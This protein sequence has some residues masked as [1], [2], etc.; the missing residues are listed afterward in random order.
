MKIEF[1]FGDI[2]VSYEGKPEDFNPT[3]DPSWTPQNPYMEYYEKMFEKL[4]SD[5]MHYYKGVNK[6]FEEY[7]KIKKSGS[8]ITPDNVK[9]L[10]A[11]GHDIYNYVAR[12]GLANCQIQA[13]LRFDGYLDTQKL[14]R[15]VRLLVDEQ[16]IFGCKFIEGDK[17]YWRRLDNID[18]VAFCSFEE[19]DNLDEAVKKFLESPLDIDIDP[20]VKLKLLRF[21]LNDTLCIKISHACCDVTGTKEFIQLLS[22]NYTLVDQYF[23][24]SAFNTVK[25]TRNDQDRLF[26]SLGINDP[27]AEWVPG[28]EITNATWPFPWQ[29]ARFDKYQIVVNRISQEQ[30]EKIV[31]YSKSRRV[32]INDLILTAYYRSM[33]EIS[34]AIYGETRE[35][36]VTVDLRRYLTDRKTEAIR[37]F[38]GAETTG[39]VLMPN[40]SYEETLSRVVSMMN[41]IKNSRPALQSAIGLER[42]EKMRFS[43]ILAY[44]NGISN[45][46]LFCPDKC[47]PVLSNV[48][49]ISNTLISFGGKIVTD[50]YIIPPVVKMPGLLLMASTYN[51]ILTLTTGIYEGS[52]PQEDIERLVN[53]VKNELIEVC[54]L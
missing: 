21:G 2:K 7:L 43:D 41:K 51:G 33:T 45:W 34:E 54:K 11:N 20:M 19:T 35:I 26:S 37:N 4:S 30:F 6:E 16:P 22:E 17:P 46:P 12:Y 53:R 31:H 3:Q 27:E 38:S 28:S 10:H 49:E 24:V 48:G 8:E 36:Q 39:I 42:L 9:I 52:I 14:L 13:V 25:R 40:E 44:Y 1:V 50:A 29:Q 18:G 5:L 23:N 32:T 15:A 47:L